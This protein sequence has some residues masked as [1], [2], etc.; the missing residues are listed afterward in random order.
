M[1]VPLPLMADNYGVVTVSGR[2]KLI[3]IQR[4]WQLV[5][6]HCDFFFE[7]AGIS[8]QVSTPF[9]HVD[10]HTPCTTMCGAV[11][12]LHESSYC[13]FNIDGDCYILTYS[14]MPACRFLRSL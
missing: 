1:S 7:V 13:A 14:N 2:Y 6:A 8:E 9:A 4:T 3:R 11:L 5:T 12:Q 10:T